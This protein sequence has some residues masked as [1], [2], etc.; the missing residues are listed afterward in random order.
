MTAQELHA[1]V[2]ATKRFLNREIVR[3]KTSGGDGLLT[4]REIGDRLDMIHEAE[5]IGVRNLDERKN[6]KLARMIRELEKSRNVSL[7]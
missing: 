1:K 6:R 5:R 4:F 2:Q 3:Q 7:N